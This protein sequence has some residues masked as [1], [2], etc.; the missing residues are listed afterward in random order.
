MFRERGFSETGMRD[1]AAA[2]D[3]SP[4]DLYHYFHG[5]DEILYYCQDRTLA[6]LM[7]AVEAARRTTPR[8]ADRLRLVLEA[9]VHTM[10]DE[11]EGATAH[12]QTEALSPVVRARLVRKRDRYERAVRQII[13]EGVRAGDFIAMDAALVAR[14]MLG[15]VNWTATWFRPDGPR[16]A[17]AV[18]HAIARFLVRGVASRSPAARRP[19]SLVSAP[20][21]DRRR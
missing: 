18:G 1:I 19:L 6:R 14:A 5:K 8:A 12:L 16:P 4:A 15:A 7:A 11:V 3:L 2:A 20:V 17:D 9:H 10:L 21:P 13:A